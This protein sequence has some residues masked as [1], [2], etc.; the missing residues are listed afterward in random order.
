MVD[1][2]QHESQQSPELHVFVILNPVAGLTDPAAARQAITHFCEDRH[3]QCEIHETIKDEDLRKLVRD[4]LKQGVDIVIA[5]GGDGTVSAVVS[6]MVN[7]KKPLGI[8]PAGTG[9]ALARDLAI[10]LDL[11]GALH[12]LDSKYAI[13][14]MDIM[15]VSEGSKGDYYVMNV[16]AG[17]TAQTM[18]KTGRE[19]KRRFGF[20]AYIYNA[21]GSILHSDFH[22]FQVKVD[23][24]QIRIN[25]TEIM[26][27][28]C[29]LMGLQ[30]QFEGVEINS[31]DHRLDM[32][33]VRTKSL[34]GYLSVLT[35]LI[36]R[37]QASKDSDLRYL[38]V[39]DQIEI[40]SNPSMPV[41]ADGEVIGKTPVKIR[42]VPGALRVI[43]PAKEE[44][45]KT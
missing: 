18:R 14:E 12:L 2:K 33:I 42:L 20:L 10:P 38:D 6:G 26:I 37:R 39:H 16:S 36:F 24:K 44:K 7:S 41:Q 1:G 15:E 8:L 45:E 31:N 40:Q 22:R 30:P 43:V 13:Q 35:R 34:P 28:N 17:I 32:F 5:A 29:K 4:H 23:N 3:W 9:N 27:A 19:E 11:E 25:A 21:I